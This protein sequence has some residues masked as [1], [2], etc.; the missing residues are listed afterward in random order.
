VKRLLRG[1]TIRPPT[2]AADSPTSAAGSTVYTLKDTEAPAGLILKQLAPRLG[3]K[4]WVDPRIAARVQKRVRVDVKD[5]SRDE[6]L[7][8]VVEPAGVS[9]TI[10]GEMLE[11]VPKR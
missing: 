2:P 1:E 5:V 10:R 11:I 4:L 6:L 7:N 9:Y 3:L 8:A